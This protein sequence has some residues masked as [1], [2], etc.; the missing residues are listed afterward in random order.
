M[1]RNFKFSAKLL[2]V[3]LVM[4]S[5]LSFAAPLSGKEEQ[6]SVSSA[7]Y[8]NVYLDTLAKHGVL[9]GYT[10]TVLLPDQTL[11]RAD[12]ATMMIKAFPD[13]LVPFL[14]GSKHYIFKDTLPS[15]GAGPYIE[16]LARGGFVQG[17]GD[18]TFRPN[19]D[20]SEQ[21]AIV[22]LS[23]LLGVK[24]FAG[25]P[26]VLGSFT[27][28]SSVSSWAKDY[29]NFM[30]SKAIFNGYPG[31]VLE[32]TTTMTVAQLAPIIVNARFPVITIL[33]T[34][35][36]HMYLLGST[37]ATTK[38]PI[39]GSARIATAVEN[40]RAYNPNT[41]L[42][43]AGDAIGGGPPIGA[44]FYGKDVIE[45]YNAIGYDIA[46][47]GNHE[48][49]WGQDLLKQRMSEAKYQYVCSN[50]VDTSTNST[51]APL[52]D[53]TRSYGFVT[54]GFFGLDTADLPELVTPAGIKG[55]RVLNPAMIATNEVS[56]LSQ[57]V[58]YVV[59]L[60]H[61]GYDKDQILAK[62]VS[63]INLIVGGHTHTVL[64]TPTIVNGT[65]IVQTGN[66]GYNLGKVVLE[67]ET[68]ADSV[69][70]LNT[71]YTLIPINDS[72][73][74]DS[75]ITAL[76]APYNAQLT[77]KMGVVIGQALVDLD[78]E[79]NDVRSKE[80]NLGDY[81]SDWMREV[82]GA[83][84]AFNDGGTI[85]ASIPKGPIT[86]G[87]V[88]TVLPFDDLLMNIQITGKQIVAAFENGFSQV[89]I[90]GGRFPQISGITVKAD[91]SKPAGSRVI[92][93]LVG[94]KPIDLDKTYT[95]VT[96]DFMGGGGDGYT[97]F[98]QTQSSKWVTGNWMRD[99]LVEYIK[100]HPEVNVTVDGRIT[101][102]T[103]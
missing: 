95:V 46:T 53:T 33:H 90:G 84:I 28:A 25:I 2:V 76:L 81:I 14:F 74:E 21:E 89:E 60:S 58:N 9:T 79:R 82:S 61:L 26:Y 36:F 68:T 64:T 101:F 72:F 20:I 99:D 92:E 4:F 40:E 16:A 47:F 5:F 34:N 31:N 51:F 103:H 100:L 42:V 102:V 48:F 98:K 15:Y 6:I 56:L 44:F 70:L 24:D 63:G 45:T 12:F 17:Y 59:A 75:T 66:Y 97:M 62:D 85:R 73:A 23:R 35:D 83:D 27:D 50:I 55:L 30:V 52:A 65:Y 77:V 11:T 3:L 88:Y 67:F 38:K 41:I 57:G 7:G 37:D 78:G 93:V 1:R 87:S 80:T 91:L 54:L 18:G 71:T 39:G 49:D 8:G 22:I 10:N 13:Q 69:K 96:Q 32:P 94:G 86:V 29:I 19:N 43:D